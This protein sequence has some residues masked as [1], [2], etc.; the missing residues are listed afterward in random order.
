MSEQSTLLVF[1]HADEAAAFT[2]LPRL[3]TGVGKVNAVVSL[4]HRLAEGGVERVVV[5]GTAGGIGEGANRL[6]LD[7]VYQVTRVLQHDFSLPSPPL[8]PSGE[9]VLPGSAHATM[10]TGDQFIQDDA[11]RA[12]IAGLGAQLVDM[13]GYAYASACERFGVPLQIFKVPSDFADSDT[14]IEDWDAVVIAKSHQL[15]EF[16]DALG[17]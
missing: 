8:E 3:V 14:T 13:E 4:S 10:A 12:H 9:V 1:A 17:A 6:S 2:D 15:R 16:W 11:Q 7:T 5:L